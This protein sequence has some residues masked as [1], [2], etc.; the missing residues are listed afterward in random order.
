MFAESKQLHPER[1]EEEKDLFNELGSKLS[2]LS[3]LHHG[4]YQLSKVHTIDRLVPILI[5]AVC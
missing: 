4:S 3:K 1:A 2:I 5:L